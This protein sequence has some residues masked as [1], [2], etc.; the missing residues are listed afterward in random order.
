MQGRASKSAVNDYAEQ[1]GRCSPSLLMPKPW[2]THHGNHR[3][4]W[5]MGEGRQE[6]RAGC[7]RRPAAATQA[8]QLLG[9]PEINPGG[10]DGAIGRPPRSSGTVKA[11]RAFQSL[12][13]FGVDGRI[14]PGGRTW[15]RLAAVVEGA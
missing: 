3:I 1:Q 6:P 13:G 12:S 10:V 5:R 2:R 15:Q 7:H 4:G 9:R 11:I 8:A 14:D